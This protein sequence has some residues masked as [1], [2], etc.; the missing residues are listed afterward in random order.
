MN[1][2]FYT[3]EDEPSQLRGMAEGAAWLKRRVERAGDVRIHDSQQ[4]GELARR[5]GARAFTA[6]RDIYVQPEL[7]K[8]FTRESAALLEHE[9]SHV[10]EQTGLA[11]QEMPL[12]RPSRSQGIAQGSASSGLEQSVVRGSTP[13]TTSGTPSIQ[14]FQAGQS[15]SESR[16]EQA[17]AATREAS[18]KKGKKARKA[19]PDP[20][21]V[22]DRVYELMRR[23]LVL[24][25]ERGAH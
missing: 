6:G 20:A 9:L 7:L 23:D 16:A 24:E 2:D 15:T 11:T 4:A 3:E 25:Y 5:L 18:R 1:D 21:E 8:P 12:L 14:R 10:A 13:A 17:E 22:A 19:P